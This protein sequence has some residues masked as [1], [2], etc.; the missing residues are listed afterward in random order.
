MGNNAEK[1]CIC[2]LLKPE[3]QTKPCTGSAW[4]V[5]GQDRECAPCRTACNPTPQL[6]SNY[7]VQ[8]CSEFQDGI[9]L[10]DIVCS[11]PSPGFYRKQDCSLSGVI[12]N[13]TCERITPTCATGFY[14]EA[15]ATA[16]SDTDCRQCPTTCPDGFFQRAPVPQDSKMR[17]CPFDCVQCSTCRAGSFQGNYGLVD[18]GRACNATSDVVCASPCPECPEDTYQVEQC[19]GNVGTRCWD[20][21]SAPK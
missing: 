19:A 10:S 18:Y 20:C 1:E 14:K 6:P 17:D 21:Q 11:C 16:T 8:R 7:L 15:D 13:A 2:S 3:Y 9:C 5:A 12:K 4:N